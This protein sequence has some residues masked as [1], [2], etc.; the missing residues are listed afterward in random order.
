VWYLYAIHSRIDQTTIP[1]LYIRAYCS[2]GDLVAI[3]VVAA[4]GWYPSEL[5]GLTSLY[6]RLNAT[7]KRAKFNRLKPVFLVSW[8]G[9]IHAGVGGSG[10][11][12]SSPRL[13][14]PLRLDQVVREQV[15][16]LTHEIRSPELLFPK[17]SQSFV[18]QEQS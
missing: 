4:V 13:I 5:F 6:S 14:L 8:T 17:W 9:Q 18:H 10:R 15:R 2:T 1:I 16:S 12:T 11:G 3:H 7:H